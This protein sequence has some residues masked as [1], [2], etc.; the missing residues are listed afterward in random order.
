MNNPFGRNHGWAIGQPVGGMSQVPPVGGPGFPQP[1][2]FGGGGFGGGMG[3][4]NFPQPA[5]FGGPLPQRGG[6]GGAIRDLAGG[7]GGKIGEG[8]DWL[9]DEKQG[10]AR[11]NLVL[12][13]LGLAGNLYGAWNEGKLQDQEHKRMEED[14]AEYDAASDTREALLARILNG[15][16]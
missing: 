16:R 10:L 3:G 15:R 7:I 6:F 14:R 5:N 13:G 1:G 11:T 2:G 4:F 8:V 9:T 12:G